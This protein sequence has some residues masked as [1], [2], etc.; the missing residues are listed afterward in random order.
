[1]C[2]MVGH[3]MKSL[4]QRASKKLLGDTAHLTEPQQEDLLKPRIHPPLGAKS[5]SAQLGVERVCHVID[6]AGGEPGIIQAGTDRTLGELMRVVDVRSL[7]MFYASESLLL[8]GATELAV[9]E[10]RG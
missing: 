3:E 5:P 4:P 2:Q 9:G 7:A 6:I 8:D 10:H 1:M